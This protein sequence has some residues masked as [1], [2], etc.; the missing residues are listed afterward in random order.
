MSQKSPTIQLTEAG[1]AKLQ[2][3]LDEL[4]K[5]KRP[6][7]VDRL[8]QARSMGDLSENS[9]YHQAKEQL[10][11]IDGRIVELESVLNQ[12]V[13]VKSGHSKK[14]VEV[15]AQVK[16]SI[17]GSQHTFNIVGEWEADPKEKKISHES[18]LGKALIGKKVGEV[19]EVDAPAGKVEYT[20]LGIE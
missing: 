17:K 15:G 12:A 18:P 3:E 7:A 16:V 6:A 2:K 13:I 10:E 8:S 5:N 11:F 14:E 4:E 9:D 1:F 20:I 19:V